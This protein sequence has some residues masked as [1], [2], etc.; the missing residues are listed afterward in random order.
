MLR[1]LIAERSKKFCH[2]FE[3]LRLTSNAVSLDLLGLKKASEEF[4]IDSLDQR[5]YFKT[6]RAVEL[7]T[8]RRREVNSNISK[9]WLTLRNLTL[10]ENEK[11]VAFSKSKTF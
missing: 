5:T 11:R 6:A 10:E 2:L 9:L 1:S 8:S 3:R 7:E 4:M